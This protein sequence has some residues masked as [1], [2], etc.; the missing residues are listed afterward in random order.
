MSESKRLSTRRPSGPGAANPVRPSLSTFKENMVVLFGKSIPKVG[1]HTDQVLHLFQKLER[2][3]GTEVA[4][5]TFKELSRY[6]TCYVTGQDSR[7]A[8]EQWLS[9]YKDG[10]P[11]CLSFARKSLSGGD[12][13]WMRFV[14]TLLGCYKLFRLPPKID[15]T[16]VTQPP[17]DP[18]RIARL[19]EEMDNHIPQ[20]LSDL[21]D[22]EFTPSLRAPIFATTKAGASGPFAIGVTS[23]H[24]L[25][26]VRR[27]GVNDLISPVVQGSYDPMQ[28]RNLMEILQN[29]A[30]AI[31]MKDIQD[32]GKL[33]ARLH[34]LSEGGGKTRTICIPDIWSQIA[35]KPIHEFL[36]SWLKGLPNDGT[37]SHNLTAL[38]LKEWTRDREVVCSDLTTATDRIPVDLQERVLSYPLGPGLA[39][40]WKS[41]LVDRDIDCQGKPVRY[42]VGQPMGFLSSWAAMA[43]T[44][45]VIVRYSAILE[46]ITDFKDYLIIGDDVAIADRRVGERY[47]AI[48]ADLEVPI[49]LGKSILPGSTVRAGE[50]AKRLFVL[51][52]EISPVPPKVLN[53]A[54][55]SLAGLVELD[56]TLTDRGYYSRSE[57]EPPNLHRDRVMSSLFFK[58]RARNS[59]AAR[60][61]LGCPFR[62]EAPLSG[63]TYVWDGSEPQFLGD[64]YTQY[65]SVRASEKVTKLSEAYWIDPIEVSDRLEIETDVSPLVKSVRLEFLQ[66]LINIQAE[67][68]DIYDSTDDFVSRLRDTYEKIVTRPTPDDAIWFSPERHRRVARISSELLNFHRVAEKSGWVS[69]ITLHSPGLRVLKP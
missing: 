35:L 22:K 19:I 9:T 43:L 4:L 31:Q 36:M 26:A 52:E 3:W 49:S 25:L 8:Q 61:Y 14:L 50:I 38:R 2:A 20:I 54:T 55:D 48:M 27:E 15:V 47:M 40:S 1:L 10:Y 41:L 65:I 69:P 46:G 6:V 42:A 62:R 51:G 32:K 56:R 18:V 60:S 33:P 11:K 59:L 58:S 37:S 68:S 30:L 44:H 39:A 64:Q 17:K 66:D 34:F 53:Q 29:S 57:Q 45:H 5:K 67:L 63:L 12:K 24:D 28:Q 23:L 21:G 13:E 16:S 7:L